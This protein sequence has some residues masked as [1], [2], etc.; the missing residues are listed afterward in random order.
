VSDAAAIVGA[1]LTPFGRFQERTLGD[2]GSEAVQHALR[3]AGIVAADIQMAFV[4]NAVGAITTGQVAVVGQ[5]VMDRSGINGIPVYNVDNACAG[6]ATA[7]NLA[8]MAIRSGAASVVLVV[9]VEK[10]YSS[11][12]ALTYRGLNGAADVE[13]SATTGADLDAESVFMKAV[14]PQ[15]LHAYSG[16]Y[17]LEPDTLA[18]IAVKNRSHAALNPLAQYRAPLTVEDVLAARVVSAPLTTLMCA[19]IGDGASAVVLMSAERARRAQ[20]RPTWI[21]ASTMSMGSPPGAGEST[22]RRLADA[23][24]AEAGIGPEAVD[25]AELHDATAFT[26]LLATEEVRLFERG[27]GASAA[28]H[29][30][31]A[32]GGRVPVNPSGG[33]ESRG[34]PVAAS[35]LAQVAEL[36]WQL[37]GEAG[38]RQVPGASVGL[39]EIAGGYVGGDSAAVAIHI[40]SAE[41]R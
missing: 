15:R 7:L 31:T 21:R 26:E 16:R 5:V 8:A 40:L 17:G 6:S 33:L 13:W 19:P 29:G 25:V 41:R 32:L 39:A 37:R 23:A 24:Y 12:R 28:V 4:A 22:I 2:L 3:D 10:L 30:E 18:R 20:Q 38:D 34:H 35:G 1:G 11:D 36:V 9:G 14:Y 27:A